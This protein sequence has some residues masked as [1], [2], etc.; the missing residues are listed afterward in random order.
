MS[1]KK[2][3]SLSDI[4]RN[5]FDAGIDAIKVGIE[6]IA[7]PTRA[8]KVAAIR[9]FYAGILLLCKHHLTR[10][11][12][13]DNPRLFISSEIH[14]K[15]AETGKV[16]PVP[17]GARTIGTQKIM[18]RLKEFEPNLDTTPLKKHANT[19]KRHRTLLH[20]STDCETSGS[21]C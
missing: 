4:E 16:R 12:P 14:F 20:I 10:H 13:P 21:L 15:K 7:S 17:I 3:N 19:Q 9:N 2:M 1:D 18:Q 8:R 5:L 6:D 11:A